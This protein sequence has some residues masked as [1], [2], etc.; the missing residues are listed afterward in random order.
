MPEIRVDS[1][2]KSYG[3]VHALR[4]VSLHVKPGEYLTIVGPSG[5]GKTTLIKSMAG[6][7]TPDIGTDHR[8]SGLNPATNRGQR[9]RICLPRD[10]SLPPHGHL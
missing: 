8:W 5:C 10:C 1:I 9:H 6:I 2:E 7:V 4:G 3:D